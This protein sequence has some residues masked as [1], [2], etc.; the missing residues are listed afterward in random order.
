MFYATI[1]LLQYEVLPAGQVKL[2]LLSA[3]KQQ[4]EQE[5]WGRAWIEACPT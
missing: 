2:A 5:E 3:L 4:R 1:V